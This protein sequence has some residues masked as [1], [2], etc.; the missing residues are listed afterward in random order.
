MTVN[1]LSG[2]LL[3]CLNLIVCLILPCK[4]SA[5]VVFIH[6]VERKSLFGEQTEKV[7]TAYHRDG[8]SIDRKRA[9]TGSFLRLFFGGIKEERETVFISLSKRHIREISWKEEKSYVYDINNLRQIASRRN[10]ARDKDHVPLVENRYEELPPKLNILTADQE[11][12][13]NGYPCR[14]VEVYMVLDTLDKLRGSHSITEIFQTL[15]MSENIPGLKERDDVLNKIGDIL[16]FEAERL[17]ALS[18]PLSYWKGSLD[19]IAQ[20]LNKVKGYPV[21]SHVRVIAHFVPPEGE[22]QKVSRTINE[23]TSI[24]TAIHNQI[25]ESL[26]AV[27]SNFVETRL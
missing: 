21:K 13:I 1:M 27:P 6:S 12:Q 23:E 8:I 14:R 24:L 16:G 22:S 2:W 7:Y 17:G 3:I 25:D 4:I 20:D 19:P 18:F 15:W 26:F 9:Y 5:D 10:E 11:E